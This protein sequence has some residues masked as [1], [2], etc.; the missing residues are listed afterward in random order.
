MLFFFEKVNVLNGVFNFIVGK[1]DIIYD[2]KSMDIVIFI[3]DSI[4][5][6]DLEVYKVDGEF[7]IN[8]KV[9]CFNFLI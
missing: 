4:D 8:K 5:V 3:N 2:M 9:I 6:R 1:I 7:L